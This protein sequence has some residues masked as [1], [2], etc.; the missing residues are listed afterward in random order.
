[1]SGE[2]AQEAA[3][4]PQKRTPSGLKIASA[5]H[6]LRN[7]V[8][9]VTNLLYLLQRNPSLNEEA[10]NYLQLAEKE[11]ERMRHVI[12]QTLADYRRPA[13]PTLV[14]L[15]DMLD[16]ILR[17]YSHKIAFKR[18]GIDKRYECEGMVKAHPEDLRQ[19]FSNLVINA[20]EALRLNGRLTIHIWQSRDWVNGERPGLRVVVADN[21]PGIL[22]EHRDKIMSD[23][24]FTT[25]GDKGTG[26]G[27]WV[28]A[29]IVRKAG[30]S[31]RFRSS[32][33]AGRSG[34]VFSVFLPTAQQSV[35][36]VAS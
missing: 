15:S 5:A 14:S 19:V 23:E 6:E 1:M 10:R 21:G 20:L 29:E 7:P 32:A 28:A 34:T 2:C 3:S 4:E 24:S 18:I 13:S 36:P 8:E 31:I 11:L 17:F 22:P 27:L 25:K 16:T 30:G 33:K 12:S 9:S 35:L 26:I